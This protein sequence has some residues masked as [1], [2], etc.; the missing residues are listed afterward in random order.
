[1]T[2]EGGESDG[3]DEFSGRRPRL[4]LDRERRTQTTCPKHVPH[5]NILYKNYNKYNN[6]SFREYEEFGGSEAEG[7]RRGEQVSTDV[8]DQQGPPRLL[9]SLIS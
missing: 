6:M 4:V 5:R 1:L 3:R 7:E 8:R 2:A 9:M